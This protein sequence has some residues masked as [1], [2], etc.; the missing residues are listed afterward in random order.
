MA[1][2]LCDYAG[3]KAVGVDEEVSCIPYEVRLTGGAGTV[4]DSLNATI[5]ELEA[6]VA[7]VRTQEH[8]LPICTSV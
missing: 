6:V 7:T 3:K 5:D 4:L 2:C 1:V 8:D